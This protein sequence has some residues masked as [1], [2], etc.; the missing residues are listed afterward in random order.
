MIKLE[1]KFKHCFDCEF[2]REHSHS[3]K[4]YRY[5]KSYFVYKNDKWVIGATFEYQN[6]GP[7]NPYFV[8]YWDVQNGRG[9]YE[10]FKT[11]KEGKKYL[12]GLV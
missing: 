8:G 6:S 3:Q 2:N 1:Y 4:D 12:E 11:V 10:F 9:D 5:M 7:E